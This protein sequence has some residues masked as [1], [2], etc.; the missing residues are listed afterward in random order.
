MEVTKL[1]ENLSVKQLQQ[2][3][4]LKGYEKLEN[5]KV[6]FLKLQEDEQNLKSL[7]DVLM[8]KQRNLQTLL[9][10]T[11]ADEINVECI[12]DNKLGKGQKGVIKNLIRMELFYFTVNQRTDQQ[13][14]LDILCKMGYCIMESMENDFNY[15]K[16]SCKHFYVLFVKDQSKYEVREIYPGHPNFRNIQQ[17]L[18]DTQD[19]KG[20]LSYLREYFL[21]NDLYIW[22]CTSCRIVYIMITDTMLMKILSET[23]HEK[24]KAEACFWWVSKLT[25]N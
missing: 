3:Q 8:E 6:T 13:G 24:G 21:D 18:S 12:L 16:I 22:D 9:E 11:L 1:E 15:V 5:L 20:M 7:N 19:L 10:K 25:L 14:N 2:V 17:F 23:F 4:L